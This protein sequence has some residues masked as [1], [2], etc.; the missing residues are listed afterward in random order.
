MNFLT[1]TFVTALSL[2]DSNYTELLA[3]KETAY[4]ENPHIIQQDVLI[5][6][7]WSITPNLL[8]NVFQN[9]CKPMSPRPGAAH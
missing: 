3:V 5:H 9:L 2:G 7:I 6:H 8:H 4:E 1:E